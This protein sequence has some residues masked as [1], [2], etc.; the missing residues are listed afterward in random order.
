MAS[1]PPAGRITPK[2]WIPRPARRLAGV[3]VDRAR[4]L[5][6]LLLERL[7]PAD[8]ATWC[9]CTWGSYLH[10]LDNPRAVFERVKDDPSIRKV[11][12]TRGGAAPAHPVDGVNVHIVDAGSPRGM[13]L[14]ARSGVVVLGYSLHFMCSYARH[15]TAKHRIVQLSHGV[16]LRNI[17]RMVPAETWWEKETPLYAA[18]I[19]SARRDPEIMRRAYAPVQRVWMTGLPRNDFILQPEAALPADYREMLRELRD[20]LNGRRMVLYAPTW[21]HKTQTQPGFSPDEAAALERLLQAH[22]AVLAVRGHSNVRHDAAYTGAF[23]SPAFLSVNEL[24]DVAVALREAEVLITDYSSIYVDFLLTGR[25]VIHYV[26]DRAAYEAERGFLY[27]LDE[28]F[29]GPAPETFPALLASLEQALARPELHQERRSRVKALFHAHPGA[30][31][32]AVADHIRALAAAPP[33]RLPATAS[34]Q[35]DDAAP[36]SMRARSRA[37]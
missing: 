35:P 14:V 6:F 4:A 33:V 19:G 29:A 28:A 7:V 31:A 5:L 34:R 32:Q 25:P 23:A 10:T 2:R 15:L 30:S 9:F 17:C 8:R 16:A 22:H 21:R 20:R 13:W 24:P 27:P 18:T 26:Y 11:V 3:A 12:L 36:R 1:T 37:A